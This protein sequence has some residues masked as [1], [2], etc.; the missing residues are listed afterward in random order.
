MDDLIRKYIPH[1]PRL[2]LYVEPNIPRDKLKHALTDYAHGVQIQEVIALFDATL[3]GS[4]KDGAVFASHRLVFQNHDLQPTQEIP[5][6]DIVGVEMKKRFLG[7][8]KIIVEANAGA[9]TVS[10]TIDFSGKGDAAPYVL[11][12]L[13]EVLIASIH[14][15]AT[16][17]GAVSAALEALVS[18]G[19]LTR[20]DFDRLM[21]ALDRAVSL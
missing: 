1:A 13:N 20:V 3:L 14:E 17:R 5:Y 21:D 7:G 9:A 12:F 2:G 18:A 11:R 10:H 15:T 6:D 19:R 16:D 4:G 8:A